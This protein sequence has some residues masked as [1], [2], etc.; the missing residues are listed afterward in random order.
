[1]K[2]KLKKYYKFLRSK[3]SGH[4]I[5]VALICLIILLVALSTYLL[6]YGEFVSRFTGMD[7]NNSGISGDTATVDDL[8]DDYNYYKGL[9]YSWV[10]NSSIPNGQSTKKFDEDY[11]VKVQITYNGTDINNSNLKGYVS[12]IG[13]EA[14]VSKYVYYKF[15]PLARDNSG[16]LLTDA[17]GNHYVHIELI[18]NPF[19]KRPIYNEREYGFNGWVCNQSGSTTNL[20]N[21]SKMIYDDDY[22]TRYMDVPVTMGQNLTI[23]L[24]ASW[25]FANVSTT[26]TNS[27]QD[28]SM[29]TTIFTQTETITETG[30]YYNWNANYHTFTYAKRTSNGSNLTRY[31]WYVVGSSQPSANNSNYTLVYVSKNNTACPAGRN[32]YCYEYTVTAN[33]ISNGDEYNPGDSYF[34][35][36]SSSYSTSRNMTG[37]FGNQYNSSYMNHTTSR[38]YT[39]EVTKS[40]IPDGGVAGGFY[41]KVS[42]PTTAQVNT[43][44]Y[45]NSDGTICT[46]RSSCTTAYKLIQYNDSLQNSDG[47]SIF[48]V[49][50][51]N[52]NIVDANN[53]YYLVTRDTNILKISGTITYTNAQSTKPYTLTGYISGTSISGTLDLSS[54][55]TA[56]DDMVIENMKV[57]GSTGTGLSNGGVGDFSITTRVFYANSKNFK[58]GRNLTNSSN[59]NN[60]IANSVVGGSS[61]AISGGFKVIVES[62]HFNGYTSGTG[63]TNGGTFNE[64]TIFG[65]DYDR[66]TNTNNK[67][68]LNVGLEGYSHGTHYNGS[69]SLFASFNYIK[70]GTF[71]YNGDGTPSSDNNAGLYITARA[72]NYVNAITGA[73][74]E[75]GKINTVVGGYGFS[76]SSSNNSTFIGMTGGNVRSIYG[77]AGTSATYGNRII[78]ATGGNVEY[79]ILGGSNSYQGSSDDGKLTSDTLVYV[80]GNIVVGTTSHISNNDQLY[81]VESGSVFGAGGGRSG[82]SYTGLGTVNNSHVIIDGGTIRGSVYGGG[83]YGSTGTQ[84]SSKATTTIDIYSG[85]IVGNVFGGSKSSG[86][87]KSNYTNTSEI[88]INGYGGTIGNIYGGSDTIGV[89]YGSTNITLVSCEVTGD[90]YGGGKGGYSSSTNSGTFISGNV[91]IIAGTDESEDNKPKVSGSIYGGS[92]YG[93][94]N[95]ST[96][97]NT[98]SSYTTNVTINKGEINQVFGGGKG[99]STYTPYVEGNVTVIVNDGKITNVFGGNDVAGSPNGMVSVYLKGGEVINTYGGGNQTGVNTTNVYLQGTDA[100]KIF[101]GSNQSGNVTTSNIIISSGKADYV[102]G[103]N[104][105]GGITTTSNVTSNG[106]TIGELY[107]GGYSASTTN[108]NVILNSGSI[109]YVY[110]GG[111]S[112]D[113]T[114][115]A[116]VILQGASINQELY[117]G[118]NSSGTVNESNVVVNNGT[119]KNVFGSNNV[120]GQTTT[121][122]VT[123]NGGNIKNAYAGANQATTVNATIILD[124]SSVSNLFG[125]G[126]S[127]GITTSNVKLKSGNATNV[128]GGSNQS[129]NVTTSNITTETTTRTTPTLNNDLLMNVTT[130]S[131][132]ASESTEYNSIVT[133]T[134]TVTNNS[135]NVISNWAGTITDLNS[136]LY[137][138]TSNHNITSSDGTYTFNQSNISDENTPFVLQPNSSH[139]FEFQIYSVDSINNFNLEEKLISGENENGDSYIQNGNVLVVSNLYGGNNQGGTTSTTNVNLNSGYIHNIYGGGNHAPVGTTNVNCTNMS[140]GGQLYGGGNAAAVTGNTNLKL[141]D[142]TVLGSSFGGGNAG[143]VNGNTNVYISSTSIGKSSYAGGNGSSA[144]VQGNTYML[145]DGTTNISNHVFGGGN[146][147]ATG[148]EVNDNSSSN[149]LIAGATIGGNVYGGANT[150]V[151]YGNTNLYLGYDPSTEYLEDLNNSFYDNLTVEKGNIH[152]VGTVFGGG[153]ANE[154]GSEEYD[155]SFISVTKDILIKIDANSHTDYDIDGSIFGS[156]NA[157]S[158]AGDSYIYIN[159]YGTTNAVKHNV[160]IQR[161]SEVDLINSHV[162]LAGAADRTNEFNTELYSLSR[163]NLLKLKNNSSLYLKS[164][165]NLLKHLKSCLDID[166]EEKIAKVTI[167]EEDGTVTQNVNN[168]LYMLE[169]KTLNILTTEAISSNGYGEVEGMTFLGMYAYDRNGEPATAMYKSGYTTGS[170]VPST[171]L[172]YFDDGSSVLGAHKTNHDITKDGFYS[173]YVSEENEGSIDVRYVGVTPENANYYMWTIGEPVESYEITLTASKYL[174]L[175]TDNLQLIRHSTPNTTFTVLGFNYDEL[176][177]TVNLLPELDVP[178][179]ASSSDDADK[180]MSLVMKTSSSGWMTNG[181][182]AFMSNQNTPM[183]GTLDYKT[184]NTS[185]APILQFYLYHSKNL[186]TSGDMGSVTISLMA[187]TR[188]DDLNVHAERVNIIVNLNRMLYNTND[189]EGSIATGKHYD[190]FSSEEINIT[191]DSSFSAYYSLYV[192]DASNF[193]KTG[194]HRSLVSDYV[195]PE[196]T[197]ITMIDYHDH[198]NPE[199]Y[200]Y[201]VSQSDYNNAVTEFNSNREVAYNLSDFVRMG[202]TSSSNN[203]SDASANIEYYNSETDTANEEFVFIVD[204]S[205]AG[206]TE[207]ISDKSLLIELRDNSDQVKVSVLGVEQSLMFYNLYNDKKAVIDVDAEMDNTYI[208]PGESMGLTVTTSFGNQVVN[209]KTITDT[210]YYDKQMGIKITIFDE[211]GTQVTGPSLLGVSYTLDGVEYYPRNDGTLRLNISERVTNVSSRIHFNTSSSL[212][213]GNYTMKIES[214]ASPDG[215]YY[216]LVSSS[217]TE[218]EFAV[219]DTLYGL[220]ASIPEKQVIIDKDTGFT[221]NK[222]NNIVLNY[223]YSSVLNNPN[224]HISLKRRKY[225][226]IYSRSYELVD[227]KDYFSNTY[228]DTSI[229]YEYLLT[230][231]PASNVDNFLYLKDNL[232]TGTYQIVLSLYDGNTKIGDVTKQ[233]IIK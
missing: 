111:K 80:G 29:Q 91:N 105:Q 138:N 130:S 133:L 143:V 158:S 167:D 15:Y 78:C 180:N 83:N 147:A 24:N 191:T 231:S 175:G 224:I 207:D 44:E 209:S 136:T 3:V 200:Y 189:Y 87:S 132:E 93:T 70:S 177:T 126:Y 155:F 196:N 11:L 221:L 8:R 206:I 193:Y 208:H 23:N 35:V 1:M 135:D 18:D 68:W 56:G 171:E 168:R 139:T 62:G 27:F 166:G 6:T 123:L 99:S 170:S 17:N 214:F 40:I 49:H 149:V 37:Y 226:T 117:G 61:S 48:Y 115:K 204:F 116:N 13:T 142:S 157:S 119:A 225:D 84:S 212:A 102:Y 94:V 7:T 38:T 42:N 185:S 228:A 72:G 194:Y 213:P 198:E 127:A 36:R 169:G 227:F 140:I 69:D 129:G 205:G 65:S 104:N 154:S 82:S 67:L 41:Y 75:G 39:R 151:V 22:Y 141:V 146:A 183:T 32:N 79:S 148:L 109:N 89:C 97:N 45:Y 86:F 192:N 218:I 90:V 174:T 51:S 12:P 220:K 181:N 120:A 232:T 153:E 145:I 195:F 162:V 34:V 152:I 2:K 9:N 176:D 21:N 160:S 85:Q 131:V 98:V 58:L 121:A 30:D 55:M 137:S 184:A 106:G 222:N 179:I 159:N 57:S 229:Q 43:G 215:I 112:A 92:A 4:R 199:Y 31:R 64:I 88:N 53:Y 144:I 201:V 114:N 150:S 50:E 71:G 19:S 25:V 47:T 26:N 186:G 161:A 101:G 182:T 217:S 16:N 230:N 113:V 54:S 96:R 14:N 210:D 173:N 77:G 216:G 28:K 172:Y 164:N 100:E 197:K 118:S 10:W 202:S 187:I 5:V 110:G 76:G 203:Y 124:G 188:V 233:I 190:L 163:V 128:F 33:G 211:N 59:D 178:R 73:K 66:I 125:G 156:G 122:L 134:V 63:S 52:G 165:A 219:L 81:N 223:K 60:I 108:T 95:G 107:G 74:I 103:G 46:N 20:C